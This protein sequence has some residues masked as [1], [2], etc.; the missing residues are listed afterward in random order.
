MPLRRTGPSRNFQTQKLAGQQGPLVAPQ[1]HPDGFIQI[2]NPGEGGNG[3]NGFRGSAVND[4]FSLQ[5]HILGR[6]GGL[7]L[8]HERLPHR[9]GE[10]DERCLLLGVRADWSAGFSRHSATLCGPPH[11]KHCI[12]GGV[13]PSRFHRL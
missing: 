11:Q 13:L 12:R 1:S 8:A 5:H 4:S 3:A 10:E 6:D 2:C 7:G 9:V